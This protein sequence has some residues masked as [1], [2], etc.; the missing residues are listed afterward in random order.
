MNAYKLHEGLIITDDTEEEIME[1][2][3]KITII[4]AWK[5]ILGFYLN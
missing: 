3:K 2:G 1:N 5:W 4:P